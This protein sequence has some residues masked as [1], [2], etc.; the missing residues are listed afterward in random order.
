MQTRT[1]IAF[2]AMEDRP[3][4]RAAIE[5]QIGRLAQRLGPVRACGVTVKAAGPQRSGR[6]DVTIRL[7]IAQSPEIKVGPPRQAVHGFDLRHQ[8]HVPS[9]SPAAPRSGAGPAK[10]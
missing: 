8:R 3:E 4:I 10:A 2:E 9:C 7:A 1:K 5:E 6:F